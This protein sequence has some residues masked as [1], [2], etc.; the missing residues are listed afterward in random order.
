M[1]KTFLR[2]LGSIGL[3]LMLALSFL[4]ALPPLSA[5]ADNSKPII[6]FEEYP[7]TLRG[8]QPLYYR[9]KCENEMPGDV[10][11]YRWQFTLSSCASDAD[12]EPK[13]LEWHVGWYECAKAKWA[14]IPQPNVL[15]IPPE[16]TL[17]FAGQD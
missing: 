4:S 10:V 11:T 15:Y 9:V 16:I 2:K 1:R 8:G 17:S 7:S 12:R 6:V 14:E 3:A 13:G 5:H